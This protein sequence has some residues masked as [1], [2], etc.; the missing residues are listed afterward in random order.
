[1]IHLI[2]K[3]VIYL[4]NLIYLIYNISDLSDL[5]DLS[6]EM[7]DLTVSKDV[8][9]TSKLFMRASNPISAQFAQLVLLIRETSKLIL[10]LNI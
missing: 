9:D 5:S 6:Q 7:D 10:I 2:K 4:I 1:M 3:T 8:K